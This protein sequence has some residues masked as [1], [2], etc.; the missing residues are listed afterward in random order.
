MEENTEIWFLDAASTTG[1]AE[2]RPGDKPRLYSMKFSR[3]YDEPEDIFGRAVSW[4]AGRLQV[5]Q[6]SEVW[7]EAP[8]PGAMM[9]GRTNAQT[10]AILFGL[11][12]ALSGVAKARRIPCYR[13]SIQTVR[14][15][16][17][18][19]GNL[20][21]PEAKRRCL[22]TCALLGW[23]APNHDAADA[24]AGWYWAVRRLRPKLMPDTAP[25]FLGGIP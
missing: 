25:L 4:L 2:G 5:S 24:A 10:T 17:I 23:D 19:H 22:A 11:W 16:F 14:K 18:G 9:H 21:G 7:I 1:V 12:G 8:I 6:P 3:E 13:A 20:P 15:V